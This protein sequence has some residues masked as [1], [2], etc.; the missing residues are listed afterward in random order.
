MNLLSLFSRRGAGGVNS[1][2]GACALALLALSLAP[3]TGLAAAGAVTVGSS[4]TLVATSDGNPA[5]TFQWKKNG[6][7]IAGATSFTYAISSVT[8]GDAGT[9]TVV[10]TNSLGSATSPDEVLVVEAAPTG[11]APAFTTQPTAT[12]T[13]ATGGTATLTAAASGSPTPTYQW[14]KNGSAISGWTTASLSLAG[15]T[16]NDTATYYVV[17][18]NSVGTAT[19]SNSALTVTAALPTTVAPAIATQPTASQSVVA[20]GSASFNVSATGTPTPTYQWRKN[21]SPISGATNTT[22]TLSSLT[23][24]DSATYTVVA[25]NSA[26]VATSNDAVLSVTATPPTSTAPVITSQPVASQSVTAGGTVT[27]SVGA[28][29]SPAPTFQWRKNSVALTGATNASLSLAL[30]TVND[31]A[32]YT[33]VVS[34]SAGAVTSNGSVLTVNPAAPTTVA[35]AITTQ[36][37]ASQSALVGATVTLT[38][39]ASGT[40]APAYQ[41]QKNS[42][43]V[44][45]ATSA[46][47]TLA[48]L[49]VSDSASYLVVATNSAG[50]ATSNASV[51]T[52]A[53]P[54]VVTPPPP[55][56]PSSGVASPP[57]ITLQPQ[58]TQTVL[59]GTTATL[60]VEASGSPTPTYQWRKN[61]AAIAGATSATLS[62]RAVTSADAATYSVIA[63]NSA[64]AVVSDSATLVVN[65]EPVFTVQPASQAVIYGSTARFTASAAAIPGPSYQ[66]RKN[67]APLAGATASVLT[68]SGVSD[69]NLGDYSV[70][71]T[72]SLGASTSQAATLVAA[73]PPV[74]T[75]QPISRTVTT[76]SNVT[77]TVKASGSP[78]PTYQWKK[79]G[80]AIAGATSATLALKSVSQ[81]DSGRYSADATNVAGW[82]SS[83]RATL[84]VVY[85]PGKKPTDDDEGAI[86]T[87]DE[88]VVVETDPKSGSSLVNLSVRANAGEG[89]GGLIVG[90]VVEGTATKDVLIRGIGPTLADFGVAGALMDPRLA[91]YSGATV[92]ASND[93]WLGNDNVASILQTSVQVGAFALPA[94]SADSALMSRLTNGAYT[95]ELSGKAGAGV[96]LVEVYDAQSG[97]GSRLVNLSVR[98]RIGTGAD[99]PSVGFVIGGTNS[100]RVMLRAVGPTLSA[101]GVTDALADPQIEL[102]QGD[103]RI[104]VNDNWGGDA[105]LSATFSRVGA[106]GFSDP[107]SRDAVMVTT[108]APGA[109]TVIVSGVNGSTGTGLV[110]LYELP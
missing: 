62:I 92:L 71:A 31:S 24:G 82:V 20:G 21:G 104:S 30:L 102:Y 72:N 13:V 99:A 35:P 18:T 87:V 33:V 109:Y 55:P 67:G 108:L 37:V 41:W 103:T 8:T 16:V 6:N 106:F 48:G 97:N 25:T 34:N 107:N 26:G 86:I 91:L 38:A 7:A 32:T 85:M 52:V 100:K 17:A 95:V 89:S 14:Y 45:G 19:S 1:G 64:G 88:P 15:V 58:R 49:A 65:L 12:Q 53:A 44:A 96:A 50:A 2:T 70:V 77:F 40:P 98:A 80:V 90:F 29:G 5:P 51:L 66:W 101:F 36:P 43:P 59:G 47:L 42:V 9:Y 93:D 54:T 28:S 4:V 39:A 63:T 76:K 56:P 22:F 60:T 61:S 3:S 83:N 27:M 68:I 10:A 74:I 73:A 81:S 110:E 78:A 69:S 84:S 23:S 94:P 79:D 105:E 46:T 11:S 57:V 75:Q